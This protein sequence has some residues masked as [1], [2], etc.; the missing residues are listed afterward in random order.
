[1]DAPIAA[2]EATSSP[3]AKRAKH[4]PEAV[5]VVAKFKRPIMQLMLEFGDELL[6][7]VQARANISVEDARRELLDP[8]RQH[9]AQLAEEEDMPPTR[10]GGE[11][12]E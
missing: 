5:D 1:M 12:G 3:P 11:C 6:D 9:L 2:A 10:D 8:L 4:S 7:G